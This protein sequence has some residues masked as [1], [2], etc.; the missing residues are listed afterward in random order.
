MMFA[1]NDSSLSS[2]QDINQFLLQVE[3]E[4]YI[5]YSIIRNFNS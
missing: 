4:P 5:S 3:I 1:F 2:D